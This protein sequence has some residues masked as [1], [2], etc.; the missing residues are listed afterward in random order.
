MQSSGEL[1]IALTTLEE[2][3]EDLIKLAEIEQ[4]AKLLAEEIERTRR[5]VNALEYV[6]IP[7]LE[8]T[9]KFIRMKLQEQERATITN[10]M[11]IKNMVEAQ[12]RMAQAA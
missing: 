11:I 2:V 4:S 8:E 7:D 1:D 3:I 12:E 5:R 9:V 10:T 6:L